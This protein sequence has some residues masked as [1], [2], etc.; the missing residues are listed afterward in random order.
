MISDE[1]LLSEIKKRLN[2]SGT[3][4]DALLLGFANDTKE[5]M[6]SGG[7][8]ADVVDSEASIG[9]ICR[10]VADLWNL[11][12]TDGHF[13]GFFYQRITQMKYTDWGLVDASGVSTTLIPLSNEDI[14][15][16]TE[17]LNQPSG[18]NGE[19][20]TMVAM[21]EDDIKTCIE[22]LED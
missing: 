9:I 5:Y 6:H 17:C 3:Y 15:E 2:I 21:S 12:G 14:N 20:L 7:V 4:H 8:P 10:G 11:G 13:S 1:V 19:Q 18:A 16:C 22:C